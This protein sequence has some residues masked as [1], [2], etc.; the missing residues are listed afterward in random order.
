MHWGWIAAL[1]AMAFAVTVATA[2]W[3]IRADALDDQTEDEW[4]ERQW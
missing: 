3:G 1:L 4:N 2:W